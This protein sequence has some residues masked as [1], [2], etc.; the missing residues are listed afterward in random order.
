MNFM[1]IWQDGRY[2]SRV[3]LSKIPTPG[4]DLEVKIADLEFSYKSQNACI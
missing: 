4:C 1:Y 3:L 2:K